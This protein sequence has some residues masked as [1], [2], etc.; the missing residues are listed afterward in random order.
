MKRFLMILAIVAAICAALP[1]AQAQAMT[2]TEWMQA[3]FT[4][5]VDSLKPFIVA[6]VAKGY[7]QVPSA[8]Q[9]MIAV[10]ELIREK[11]YGPKNLEEFVEEAAQ[12]AGMQP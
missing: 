8:G 4:D 3:G 12:K 9:L 6:W 7:K 5:Q 11:G 10:D 1:V 2:G